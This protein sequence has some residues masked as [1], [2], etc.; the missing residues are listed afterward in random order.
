MALVGR[1]HREPEGFF[2][3]EE[4]LFRR[5]S[6]FML[7]YPNS[8][9]LEATRDKN[10]ID[11]TTIN[12]DVMRFYLND[13][14]VD[15]TKPVTINVNKRGRFEG[16]V[17]PSVEEMLNDQLFLG[18]GWRYYTAV[19]NIDSSAGSAPSTRPTTRPTTAR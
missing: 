14:M 12:V 17:K 4:L 16:I 8:W 10:R 6:G 3:L 7:V 1:T 15:L 19:V 9:K 18:R 5:G 2:G 13:Q 11:A